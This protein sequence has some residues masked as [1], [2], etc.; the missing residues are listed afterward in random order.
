MTEEEYAQLNQKYGMEDDFSDEEQTIN[1]QEVG[2]AGGI[3][4][5]VGQGLSLG[6]G[7][8]IEA[9]AKS[10][11]NVA[12]QLDKTTFCPQQ[13]GHLPPDVLLTIFVIHS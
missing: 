12:R 1:S 10:G 9:F 2:T 11:F 6:F 5:A 4:R 3:A 8:E 7:D 13:I